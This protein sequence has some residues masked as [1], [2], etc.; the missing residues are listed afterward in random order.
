MKQSSKIAFF[1]IC[2]LAVGLSGCKA[3]EKSEKD[4]T[5]DETVK[6]ETYNFPLTGN[7]TDESDAIETRPVAVVVNNHPKARP[8]SG[9]NEADLIYE[10]LAEGDVTRFLAIY[11]SGKP[12]AIGPVRSA[13]DYFIELAEGYDALFVAHGWSPKAK[14]MLQSGSIDNINGISYDGTLFNRASNRKAPHNS[15]ISYENIEKGAEMNDY[16]MEQ[17]TEPLS[18]LSESEIKEI[19][20][21]QAEKVTVHYG[22]RYSATYEYSQSDESYTRYNDHEQTVDYETNEPIALD[23]IFIVEANHRVVDDDGRREI[24]LSSGGHAILLQKGLVQHI[25][26]ENKDGRIVPKLA[27]GQ[28]GFVHGRTWIHIIPQDPGIVEAVT[29]AEAE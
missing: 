20:G 3:E 17:K 9:L 5:K 24:D 1:L 10:L 21:E 16:A 2:L 28:A 7:K 14:E 6:E 29:I 12:E 26:W 22:N 19:K 27:D 15:Y 18:F 25:K 4:Q 23:N 13:R 8:Q 11:Q